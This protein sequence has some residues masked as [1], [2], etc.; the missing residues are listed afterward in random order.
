MQ[1][2]EAQH[3]ATLV[4]VLRNRGYSIIAP[5]LREGAIILEEI[6][7]ADELPRG[8]TDEQGPGHYA[9]EPREDRKLFGYA[10][11]PT[12]WKRFLFPPNHR[13]FAAARAGKGFSVQSPDNSTAPRY[14]FLGVRACE[15][16]AIKVQDR[17]FNSGSYVD[18]HYRKV[19][20]EAL[21]IGVNCGEAR[22]TCFCVSMKTGPRIG[23]GFDLA[24]TEIAEEGPAFVVEIGSQ[25]GKSI[26]D[27]IPHRKAEPAEVEAAREE[28]ERAAA[29]MG[30]SI[31]TAG[32]ARALNEGFDHPRWDEV[33]KRCMSCANCT[34]VCPTCFCST[35]KETTDL[36]GDHAERW[37]RWDSCF[38][39]EFTKIAGGNIRMSTRTRYRQW[40][41]H[42]FAHW[43]DQFG[44]FGCVGCGRCITWCP[45]GIN[46]T[47]EAA[48][49]ASA[50][51]L[52]KN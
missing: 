51:P 47:E 6:A 9:L 7:S 22:G 43:V 27:E 19:R 4:E 36:T 18:Q 34:M 45:A 30:Q 5:V 29:G 50:A 8:W 15:L 2:L 23:E 49:V 21:I 39:A 28:V 32:I 3:L 44:T 38:T 11:G 41:M 24:L 14:A 16:E 1:I 46:I 37:R 33:A 35:V 10:V 31:D 42:K 20:E 52:R 48:A 17:V 40:V 12:A 26:L 25:R 13:L